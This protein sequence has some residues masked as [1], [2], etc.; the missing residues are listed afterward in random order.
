MKKKVVVKVVLAGDGGVG[1]TT[2]LHRY[3]HGNFSEFTKMT[4]GLEF[5]LKELDIDGTHVTI[6]LWDFGGQE[7]FQFL[8]HSYI[9][10]A[11]GAVLMYDLTRP[12]TLEHLD[13]WVK[14]CKNGGYD[15]PIVFVGSKKDIVDEL[16][17]Q[18]KLIEQILEDYNFC[19]YFE[20]SS[21]TGENVEQ[22]FTTLIRHILD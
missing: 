4:I 7:Q 12:S 17:I 5:F 20:T 11:K 8:H 19:D 13:Y 2:I 16:C 1:K 14:L 6:Q 15:M 10:G 3:I 9:E 18:D 21:K 22:V